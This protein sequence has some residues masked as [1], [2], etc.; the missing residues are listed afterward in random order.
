MFR[1]SKKP[2]SVSFFRKIDLKTRSFRS[3]T[4]FIVASMSIA[5]FTDI[6]LY[7]IVVPVV[8]F[9]FQEKFDI[10]KSEIQTWTTIA[11]ALYSAGL[12]VGALVFGYCA[13]KVQKRKGPLLAGLIVLLGATFLLCFANNIGAYIAGRVLQGISGGVVWT[14]GLAII[15]DV[16]P[17]DK[18]GFVMS[19]PTMGTFFGMVLGPVI[20]GVVYE[21]AGYYEVF[22]VCFAVLFFDIVLRIVMIERDR[23][24]ESNRSLIE[25]ERSLE[26]NTALE[27]SSPARVSFLQRATP[28]S[29]IL[30][31]NVRFLNALLQTVMWGWLLSAMDATLSLHLNEIFGFDSL[32]SGLTFLAVGGAAVFE[33]LIGM[34]SD[35]FGP[36]Y[37][38]TAG[39][40]IM[41]PSFILLR[42]PSNDSPGHI[43]LCMV[44]LVL[45][46][47]GISTIASPTMADLTYVTSMVDRK[48]PG[49]LGRGKG[50]GQAY[51]YFNVAYSVGTLVGPFE[52]GPVRTSK[53]WGTE[54]LSLGIMCAIVVVPSFLITGG[55]LFAKKEEE[56][57]TDAGDVSHEEEN[58]QVP[59]NA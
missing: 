38:V 49:K 10:P 55:Y 22:I 56:D 2:D 1:H 30:L 27:E 12:I 25:E 6:F 26:N 57:L 42:I 7:T 20:G 50:F 13:D 58:K 29:F 34:L 9:A 19:F 31:K 14:V 16:T 53:G 18:L 3:S 15:C 40:L 28:G 46:G 47:L 35:K 33:P 48:N 52:A 44:L 11:L 54:V 32:K 39:Y 41:C 43:A 21:R 45:V 24:D 36:R 23:D 37:C 8:P 59:N 51:G 5:V 4:S 17:P